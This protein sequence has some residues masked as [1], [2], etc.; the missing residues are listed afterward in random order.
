MQM[1]P[2]DWPRLGRYVRERRNELG[3]TQEEIA[4]RGGP[5]TATLRLIEG[6]EQA[7]F[8]AKSLR[9]LADALHWTPESPRA[10]LAGREPVEAADPRPAPREPRPVQP[11][12]A[13]EEAVPAPIPLA[14]ADAVAALIVSVTPVIDTEI[15][16]ARLRAQRQDVRGDEVFANEHEAAVWDLVRLP[17]F[18]RVRTIATL[19]AHRLHDEAGTQGGRFPNRSS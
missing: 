16:Q 7:A 2:P 1:S 19:R 10:I 14:V 18:R 3:L 11:E 5:S 6:G 4:T 12:L 9:Q 15:R 17:E 8:R 13:A